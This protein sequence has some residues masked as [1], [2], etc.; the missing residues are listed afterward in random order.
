MPNTLSPTRPLRPTRFRRFGLSR[1][2]SVVGLTLLSLSGCGNT[3]PTERYNQA[4]Q[5]LLACKESTTKLQSQLTDQER[6]IRTLQ[7]QVSEL[8]SSKAP[9][10]DLVTVDRIELDR[11]SAGYDTDGKPGDDGVV[12]Y[13]QPKDKEGAVLKVAG[14]LKV[15]LFDLQNPPES[16]V[17]AEYNFDAKTTRGL[18]FGR[19]MTNHFTI[20]CP[21]P[22]RPAHDRI[23][24][25][26]VFTELLTG[27]T[28]R[29]Q[30]VYTLKLG[31]ATRPG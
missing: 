7:Q 17:L 6:S 26:V 2:C 14:T 28:F 8:R 27:R 19:L 15:T 22:I 23:T 11:L 29:A 1:A 25:E 31:P 24:A 5:E 13:V 21:L 10:D 16:N 9:F 30:G 20:R 4:Q 12:L 18:W 3:V